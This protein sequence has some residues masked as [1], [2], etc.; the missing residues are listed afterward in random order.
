MV[1]LSGRL[2][3]MSTHLRGT[4][5]RLVAAIAWL[6]CLL[7]T[8]CGVMSSEL[9]LHASVVPNTITPN[10]DS[11][12]DSASI[13]VQISRDAVITIALSSET[14]RTH[15]LRAP[16]QL[17]ASSTPYTLSFDG[18]VESPGATADC[19]GAN[20]ITRQ[21]LPSGVYT[22]TVSASRRPETMPATAVTGTITIADVDSSLP[23]ICGLSV[24]PRVF[25]PNQDGIDDR[26]TVNLVADRDVAAL[27]VYLVGADGHTYDIP[28][29]ENL[30]RPGERG[31]HTFDY[32]GGIDAG[33][34]PPENGV[35]TLVA[36]AR[37]HYGQTAQAFSSLE[38]RD[39]GLPRA[40]IAN[41]EAE[42]SLS[43]VAIQETFC[44]SVTV[45]NESDTP[46]RTAGPWSGTA[47]GSGDNFNSLGW[48]EESGAFRVGLDYESSLR[49]YP[50]RWGL[51]TP[52]ADLVQVGPYWYLPPHTQVVVTGCVRM[53]TEPV[54]NPQHYWVGLIHEDVEIAAANDRVNPILV[55]VRRGP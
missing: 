9:A 1:L 32:D 42:Y 18:I 28:E 41:A 27:R 36:E 14:G 50:Y 7:L 55:T 26:A 21:L 51:G 44:Y 53:D 34:S 39:A 17:R 24:Y 45:T 6:C 13:R 12:D 20:M 11:L 54:I 48:S 47:Y 25:T 40:Y 23:L 31:F 33:I 30:S 19:A 37:D 3:L 10:G 15:I 49:N 5:K 22:W 46:L 35:Y 8:G 52:G 38:I 16:T 2:S 43:D 4:V 29:V